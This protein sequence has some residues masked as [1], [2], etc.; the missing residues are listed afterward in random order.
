M[1]S[2][3]DHVG[4]HYDGLRPSVDK[5][6]ATQVQVPIQ[7]SPSS[8]RLQHSPSAASIRNESLQ[9]STQSQGIQSGAHCTSTPLTRSAI[10]AKSITS[11]MALP[12]NSPPR[13]I[14]PPGIQEQEPMTTVIPEC[15][16]CFLQCSQRRKVTTINPEWIRSFLG[17][18]HCPKMVLARQNFRC[19][20]H[21]LVSP[22]ISTARSSF[23]LLWLMRSLIQSSPTLKIKYVRFLYKVSNI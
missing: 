13:S 18:S 17:N 9:L 16:R 7:R 14:P 23:C 1:K 4:K 22:P 21:G 3:T 12:L 11:T 6:K 2:M 10:R 15:I 20:K 5:K 19:I 8:P